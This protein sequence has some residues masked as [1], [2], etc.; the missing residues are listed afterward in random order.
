MVLDSLPILPRVSLAKSFL[1]RSDRTENVPAINAP[2]DIFN[3]TSL[4]LVFILSF[5]LELQNTEQTKL[6]GMVSLPSLAWSTEE[7]AE[8]TP[9]LE[10]VPVL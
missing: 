7:D 10:T 1:E 4:I 5:F 2:A 6:S 8:E 3:R 9:F